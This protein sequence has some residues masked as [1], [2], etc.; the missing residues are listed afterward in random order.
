MRTLIL[1]SAQTCG[2]LWGY[3]TP[4]GT[5]LLGRSN[6]IK[7]VK[8]PHTFRR[9][10]TS[11]LI[12]VGA[13]AANCPRCAVMLRGPRTSL[14]AYAGATPATRIAPRW[15]WCTGRRA[16]APPAA[17]LRG[18][19]RRARTKEG[20]AGARRPRPA[21]TPAMRSCGFPAEGETERAGLAERGGVGWGIGALLSS[22][23]VLL[24]G[25]PPLQGSR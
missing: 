25:H 3:S 15:C 5:Q 20:P 21:G 18:C 7:G 14:P 12:K 22:P 16:A 13:G 4:E 6:T 2:A 10:R 11:T 24:V 8:W 1:G 17:E 19:R 23:Q 9:T